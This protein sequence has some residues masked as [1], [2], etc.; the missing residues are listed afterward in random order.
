ML[1]AAETNQ[2]AKVN[3]SGVLVINNGGLVGAAAN[4]F[5]PN[6]PG[7]LVILSTPTT[8]GTFIT[9]ANGSFSGQ[10]LLPAGLE[11]GDHTVVLVTSTLSTSLGV[12]VEPAGA[13]SVG[14]STPFTGPVVQTAGPMAATPGQTVVLSGSNLAGVTAARVN[15]LIAEVLSAD[16]N[17][18]TLRLPADITTGTYDLV[19]TS[20]QGI[21]TIQGAIRIQAGESIQ[22]VGN[23]QWTKATRES[24]GSIKEVKM[25]AKNPV[26][27]GKIQFF[28]NGRE[29]AWVRSVD[30][31]DPKLRTRSNGEQ[32]L[33]RT[34]T[35]LPGKNALEIYIDGVRV[36]RAAY[37]LR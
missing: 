19:L 18:L 20:P 21:V 7:E 1:A 32:Y 22:A 31:T 15:G 26:G 37:T 3:A 33:V 24:D 10:A 23:G 16:A 13:G 14:A 36:W 29:I 11:N 5:S 35:L 17:S 25:Y 6:T 28:Q 2:P 34:V 8:L 30:E 4:G 9:D 12:T 27:L